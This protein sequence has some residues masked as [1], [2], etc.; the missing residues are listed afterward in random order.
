MHELLWERFQKTIDLPAK[1]RMSSVKAKPSYHQVRHRT[2]KI[3]DTLQNKRSHDISTPTLTPCSRQTWTIALLLSIPDSHPFRRIE[4]ADCRPQPWMK[5][6]I[7]HSRAAAF[8]MDSFRRF[9][10]S[11]QKMLRFQSNV[12]RQQ[13]GACTVNWTSYELATLFSCATRF[14]S[15]SWPPS[16]TSFHVLGSCIRICST[17]F[18]KADLTCKALTRPDSR[19]R[20]EQ[21]LFR[22]YFDSRTK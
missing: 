11:I 2:F 17:I 16:S 8:T 6:H 15:S 10:H 18:S 3:S 19:S 14:L 1:I 12:H 21:S 9:Q 7:L 4:N 13:K 22:L 5:T 20:H